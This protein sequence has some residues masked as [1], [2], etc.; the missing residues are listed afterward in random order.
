MYLQSE[1]VE[2]IT[3][4][5]HSCW[6][7]EVAVAAGIEVGS[8]SISFPYTHVRT[9]NPTRYQKTDEAKQVWVWNRC[10]TTC[11]VVRVTDTGVK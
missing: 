6:G 5:R 3:V 9:S 8:K 1:V 11:N 10:E 2:Y 7:G 4:V